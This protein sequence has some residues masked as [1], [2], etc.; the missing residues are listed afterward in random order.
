MKKE[1]VNLAYMVNFEMLGI[2]LTSGANQVYMTGYNL[3]DMADKMNAI[4]L[5]LFNSSLKQKNTIY[6]V[7]QTTMPFTKPLRFQHKPFLL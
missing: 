1:K 4:S 3:S 7:V 2:T 6:F 5:I